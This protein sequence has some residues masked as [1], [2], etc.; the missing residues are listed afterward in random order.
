VGDSVVGVHTVSAV[1][2]EWQGLPV[3]DIA[4]KH[5]G[6]ATVDD[7]VVLSNIAFCNHLFLAD[8]PVALS[9]DIAAALLVT[10]SRRRL[11]SEKVCGLGTHVTY[12]ASPPAELSPFSSISV[13][14]ASGLHTSL[15]LNRRDSCPR[16]INFFGKQIGL[17]DV[18]SMG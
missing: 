18:V 8:P 16:I 12:S 10:P 4:V 7:S 1:T 15:V 3:V 13:C 9:A 17:S 6:D 14:T 2:T 11:L 5:A